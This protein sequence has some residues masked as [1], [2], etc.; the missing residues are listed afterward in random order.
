MK[1]KIIITSEQLRNRAL[2]VCGSVPL[3]TPHVVEIRPHKK[4][5]SEQQNR[6]Y[7]AIITIVAAD[8]GL[9]KEEMHEEYIERFLVPIFIRDDS[10]YAEMVEAVVAADSGLMRQVV[11]L[12]STTQCSV[13][14]FGEYLDEIKHN[15]FDLGIRL[16]LIEDY[17]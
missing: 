15:A 13:K 4:N 8:L 5:R 16:P 3:D 14:Q 9:S 17:A 11:R 2:Q 12:T 1:A 7:W 10:G 6:Y